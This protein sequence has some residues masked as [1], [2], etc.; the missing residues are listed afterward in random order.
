MLIS[1]VQLTVLLIL[2]SYQWCSYAFLFTKRLGR[3]SSAAVVCSTSTTASVPNKGLLTRNS[4]P[5]YRKRSSSNGKTRT[6]KSP[7][8]N[9][10]SDLQKKATEMYIKAVNDF[11]NVSPK[12]NINAESVLDFLLVQFPKQ[13]TQDNAPTII[14][15]NI[16]I[17]NAIMNS[18]WATNNKSKFNGSH[19][20]DMLQILEKPLPNNNNNNIKQL[21]P[22]M[23][24]YSIVLQAMAKCSMTTGDEKMALN[25]E[26]ILQKMHQKSHSTTNTKN[27]SLRH[28]KPNTLDY[29]HVMECWVHA[30]NPKKATDMLHQMIQLY[31]SDPIRYA[32][33]RP[34]LLIYSTAIYGWTKKGTSPPSSDAA[35]EAQTLLAQ[36]EEQLLLVPNSVSTTTSQ[37]PMIRPTNDPGVV[38]LYGSVM[39]CWAKSG[40]PDA[41]EMAEGILNNM[42]QNSNKNSAAILVQP[43]TQIYNIVINAWA[44]SKK[45]NAA[46]KALEF[47]SKMEQ[48]PHHEKTSTQQPDTI[49]YNTVIKA[50]VNSS[51]GVKAAIQSEELLQKMI[52]SDDATNHKKLKPD[53]VTYTSVIDCWAKSG[54]PNAAENANKLLKDMIQMYQS[55]PIQHASL[56]PNTKLFST[57]INCWAKCRTPNSAR[58][59]QDMLAEMK[60]L[61]I[62]PNTI[63]YNTVIHAWA[64]SSS[65]KDACQAVE[66][67]LRQMHHW[68]QSGI[69]P[70]AKPNVST[71]IAVIDCASRRSLAGKAE[72]Y[73]TEMMDLYQSDPIRNAD[74]RPNSQVY[75]TVMNAYAKSGSAQKAQSILTRMEKEEH[76]GPN[77]V[78]YNTVLHSFA[79]STGGLEA[80]IEAETI[81]QKMHL[82]SAT[83]ESV[84]PDVASYVAVIDC[85][86]KS[87]ARNS[88]EKASGLLNDMIQLYQ[89]DTI[90]YANLRPM[91]Q[92]FNA[93]INAW[94]KSG[95]GVQAPMEAQALLSQMEDMRSRYGILDVKPDTITYNTIITA[96]A[97]SRGGIDAAIQA[98]K[99]LHKMHQIYNAG[100]IHV[101][102][103]VKTY[104][105]VIDCW[106]NAAGTG[107]N[108][109]AA[110]K[111]EQILDDMI[112]LYQSDR[113]KYS[114]MAPNTQVINI[115]I[116]AFAI[117]GGTATAKAQKIL[118]QMEKMYSE[119]VSETKPDLITYNTV[120]KALAKSGGGVEAAKEAEM[121]LQKMYQLYN[122]GDSSMKPNFATYTSVVLT[123]LNSGSDIAADMGDR[124]LADMMKMYETDPILHESLRPED[125]RIF[126]LIQSC[127]RQNFNN[128]SF[129]GDRQ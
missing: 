75:N 106:A 124:I 27:M 99:I 116:N 25:A 30:E 100:N 46:D 59:A 32:S 71:Y 20:H 9:V 18:L 47:L 67:L 73:L 14:P 79:K 86:A 80:A 88:G 35:M 117:S 128:D 38:I 83:D 40:H 10:P 45:K 123:W 60:T 11:C 28:N 113:I 72:S 104:G 4:S 96:W 39:N 77:T 8:T 49:T 89:S 57:V 29:N 98:E 112:K 107:L 15:L 85:W 126:A 92:V 41:A 91:T 84:M 102:P 118:T 74:L 65:G 61:Q 129:N 19:A 44:N 119:G 78:S 90:K 2:C 63:T 87:G 125:M 94:A 70:Y 52:Q 22:N 122:A 103:N 95:A 51:G 114:D 3:S 7:S 26:V 82:L 68:Y 13:P 115:V 34:N 93:V 64:K 17:L 110:E 42:I 12:N 54:A 120:I 24:T 37:N 31:H 21:Q 69:N 58:K 101:K 56:K 55:D 53:V 121:L 33:L 105:S 43:N 6:N 97:K 50:L 108:N 109:V 16:S 1:S 76:L 81:L 127:R 5:T 62:L 66:D 111:A 23:S 48:H 36:M